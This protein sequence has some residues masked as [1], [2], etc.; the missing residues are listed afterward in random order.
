MYLPIVQLSAEADWQLR[1]SV[2]DPA[3]A[4]EAVRR[5][6][7]ALAQPARPLP[8]RWRPPHLRTAWR[9]LRHLPTAG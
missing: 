4:R 9:S 5:R 2:T 1:R 6:E 8:C 7:H 3:R